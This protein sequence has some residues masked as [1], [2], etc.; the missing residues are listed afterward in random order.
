MNDP[1]EKA[2]QFSPDGRTLVAYAWTFDRTL[3]GHLT[4][5]WHAPSLDEVALAEGQIETAPAPNNAADW[6]VRAKVL[7]KSQHFAAA[8]SA[9][10]EVLSHPNCGPDAEALRNAA[11]EHRAELWKHFGAIEQAGEDNCAVLKIAARDSAAPV[12]CI[13]LSAFFNRQ[14]DA[15]APSTGSAAYF[16]CLGSGLHALERTGAIPFDLR[17]AIRL[18][19][20]GEL[21]WDP[22]WA[23]AIRGWNP[24]AARDLPVRQRCKRLHFLESAHFCEEEDTNVGM[25]VVH[26]IDGEEDK[27]DIRYGQHVRDWVFSVDDRDL[28]K[29]KVAWVGPHPIKDTVRAFEQT[30]DNQRPEVEIATLDFVS[31]RSW[32]S[33]V[34]LAITAEPVGA[35]QR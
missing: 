29:G 32:T 17:G 14:L 16:G 30:W 33:P 19:N 18:A 3:D 23:A 6:L 8:L 28:T 5:F 1:G 26:Y 27:V 24:A 35:S 21:E 20:C 12:E 2:V 34:L 15:E 10:N 25:Y 7:M 31:T 4:R 9:F 22:T 11:L 13:D